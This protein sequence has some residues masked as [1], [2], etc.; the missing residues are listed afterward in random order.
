MLQFFA[1]QV[2]PR[3][4]FT[5]SRAMYMG[6]P[7]NC[8]QCKS[9]LIET[10]EHCVNFCSFARRTWHWARNIRRAFGLNTDASWKELAFGIKPG[11]HR[12]NVYHPQHAPPLAT[13]DVFRI[14]LL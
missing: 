7:G 13:W 2:A 14:A 5:G 4:L 12:G 11:I 1:W 9:G 10:V 8:V 6:H 3:G